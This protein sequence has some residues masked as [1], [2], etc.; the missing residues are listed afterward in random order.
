MNAES[1]VDESDSAAS[2]SSSDRPVPREWQ[3]SLRALLI[4]TTVVSICLALGTY[5][6]GVAFIIFAVVLLEVATLLS[7]DWLIRPANRPLLAFVTAGSWMIFGSGLLILTCKTAYELITLDRPEELWAA[8]ALCA[9]TAVLCYGFGWRR[10]RQL[11]A[12]RRANL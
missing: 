3:F 9:F 11:T 12:Y 4:T 1:R 5:L 7:V 10:W 8:V 6:A 2:R